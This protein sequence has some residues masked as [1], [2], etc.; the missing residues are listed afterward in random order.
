MVCGVIL[1][2]APAMPDH[3]FQS[4]ISAD[5]SG[6][7]WVDYFWMKCAVAQIRTTGLRGGRGDELLAPLLPAVA[8][9]ADVRL[10]AA[11]QQACRL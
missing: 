11:R 2:L 9:A 6:I 4:R 1:F 8:G 5:M 7:I 3:H 10:A